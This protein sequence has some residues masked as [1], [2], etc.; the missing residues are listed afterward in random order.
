[1]H[2]Q[3][4][5]VGPEDLPC[6]GRLQTVAD[7]QFGSIPCAGTASVVTVGTGGP[8][9]PGTGACP[10][11]IALERSPGQG[12]S[13]QLQPGPVTVHNARGDALQVWNCQLGTSSGQLQL[14][15]TAQ[16]QGGQPAGRYAGRCYLQILFH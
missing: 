10:A 9:K 1:V 5:I 14:G 4:R 15:G 6:Q 11:L 7:L 12:L 2:V 16:I 13:F 3:A 8:G